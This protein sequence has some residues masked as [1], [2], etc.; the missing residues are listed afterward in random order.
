MN[1]FTLLQ[2]LIDTHGYQ[3]FLEIG[4]HKGKTFLP[5]EC[6]NKT[7][8]DPN[9]QISIPFLLKWLYK[10]PANFRNRYYS[11]TSD[12]FFARKMKHI[13]NKRKPDL[14]F[15]DGLHTF[16]ASLKDVLN[17]LKYLN[18]NGSIVL[19][20]CFPP[21][22]ASATPA[23]SLKEAAKMNIPDWEGSWCGDVW[24]TIVYLREF[25]K[26][27]LEVIVLNTDL[28]LGLIKNNSLNSIDLKIDEKLFKEVDSYDFNFLINNPA[29]SIGLKEVEHLKL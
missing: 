4:T 23:A 15:I 6:K 13:E 1:R 14:I 19:H 26:T 9:F 8:V 10:K 20:D 28:G 24:K 5:L 11:M 29:K 16:E 2:Q 21:T 18:P 27:E 22:K 7:A 12:S 3:N 17:S 25:Y